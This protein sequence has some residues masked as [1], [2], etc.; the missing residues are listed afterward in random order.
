MWEGASLS[1]SPQWQCLGSY[2]ILTSTRKSSSPNTSA[3]CEELNYFPLL[4]QP[5]FQWKPF[6]THHIAQ[7]TRISHQMMETCSTFSTSGLLQLQHLLGLSSETLFSDPH[8]PL[9]KLRVS[10][11]Q[12]AGSSRGIL[13][14][15]T[16]WADGLQHTLSEQPCRAAG[17]SPAASCKAP[18][19]CSAER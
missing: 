19:R 17:N 6:G 7:G 12:P 13:P 9:S 1:P 16:P 2:W 10:V 18:A 14:S 8:T 3:L 5:G 15:C 11:R 4:G